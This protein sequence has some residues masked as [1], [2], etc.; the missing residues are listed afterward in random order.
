MLTFDTIKDRI[1]ELEEEKNI[2]NII[3]KYNKINSDI[4]TLNTEILNLKKEFVN[5]IENKLSIL[6]IMPVFT[7]KGIYL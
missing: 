1:K 7:L 2:S 6:I 3:K 5:S 4:K